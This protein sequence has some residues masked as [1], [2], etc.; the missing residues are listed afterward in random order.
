M[1]LYK[2]KKFEE[3]INQCNILILCNLFLW[4]NDF[5]ERA[6]VSLDWKLWGEQLYDPFFFFCGLYLL[7]MKK[8]RYNFLQDWNHDYYPAFY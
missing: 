4:L 7:T 6:Q 1:F 2:K 3:R 5:S 8:S